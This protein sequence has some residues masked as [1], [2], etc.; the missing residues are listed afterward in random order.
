ML[1]ER[2]RRQLDAIEH[3]LLRDAEFVSAIAGVLHGSNPRR[4]RRTAWRLAAVVWVLAVVVSAGTGRY[5]L[6]VALALLASTVCLIF[7]V[8]GLRTRQPRG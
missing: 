1:S 6:S 8:Y 3:D 2:E 7:A 5:V 4:H